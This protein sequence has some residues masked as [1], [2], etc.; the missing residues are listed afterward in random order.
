M[1]RKIYKC[2]TNALHDNGQLGRSMTTN[3]NNYVY[4]YYKLFHILL[5]KIS[6]MGLVLVY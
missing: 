5:E 3:E 6:H 2:T 1:D 4:K